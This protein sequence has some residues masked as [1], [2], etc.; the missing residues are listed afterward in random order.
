MITS[1]LRLLHL[2][3]VVRHYFRGDDR[4]TQACVHMLY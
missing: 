4:L 1:L 2:R 3:G